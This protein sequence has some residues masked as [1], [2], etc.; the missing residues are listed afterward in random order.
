MSAGY[1]SQN[2]ITEPP[3]TI[4]APTDEAFIEAISQGSLLCAEGRRCIDLL[5]WVHSSDY[6][7]KDV[8]RHGELNFLALHAYRSNFIQAQGLWKDACIIGTGM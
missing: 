5:D 3:I 2:K 4:F 8:L 1:L 6:S 7:S